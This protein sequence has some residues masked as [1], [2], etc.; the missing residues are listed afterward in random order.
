MRDCG[1]LVGNGLRGSNSE[2]YLSKLLKQINIGEAPKI[3]YH[4]YTDYLKTVKTVKNASDY[5]YT[6]LNKTKKYDSIETKMG[7]NSTDNNCA[8][9]S[10]KKALQ[11]L[12]L[13]LLG[14][15]KASREL[16]ARFDKMEAQIQNLRATNRSLRIEIEYLKS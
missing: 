9:T 8:I 14:E 10:Q 16:Q 5:P 2:E 3:R 11:L 12:Q 4:R 15:H 1:L 13:R 7:N 6:Q